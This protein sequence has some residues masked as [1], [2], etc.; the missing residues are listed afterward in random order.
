MMIRRSGA[1]SDM[2]AIVAHIGVFLEIPSSKTYMIGTREPMGGG[3]NRRTVI[4]YVA[5]LAGTVGVYLWIRYRGEGLTAPAPPA[6]G[7]GFGV[8]QS[9]GVHGDALMHVLLALLLVI[10]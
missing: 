2:W 4:G 3:G 10:L 6:G 9:G 7:S 5:M 1:C 8:A